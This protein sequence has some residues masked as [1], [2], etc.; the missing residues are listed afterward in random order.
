MKYKVVETILIVKNFEVEADKE[1]QA[2]DKFD[3]ETAKLIKEKKSHYY[4]IK[5]GR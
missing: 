3:H 5:E 2:I 4:E 1:H